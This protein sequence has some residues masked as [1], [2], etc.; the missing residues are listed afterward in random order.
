MARELKYGVTTN[1]WER[2]LAA[3]EANAQDFQHLEAYRVEL[4]EALAQLREAATQQTALAAGKQTETKRVQSLLVTGR[5]L[6][7]FL[8]H[9]VRRRYGDGSEKLAEFDLQPFRG[10]PRPE[11]VEPP[12]NPPEVAASE[13]NPP[14]ALAEAKE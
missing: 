2:L 11:V 14:P 4:A 12:T 9:G 8:R 1:G 5:K 10:R 13:A 6:A 7:S 3:L